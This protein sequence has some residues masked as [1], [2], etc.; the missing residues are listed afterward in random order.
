M[1]RG[2]EQHRGDSLLNEWMRGWPVK[3]KLKE[4]LRE[5]RQQMSISRRTSFIT[6][7]T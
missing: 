6:T 7:W 3:V 1:E 2:K 4:E 5:S